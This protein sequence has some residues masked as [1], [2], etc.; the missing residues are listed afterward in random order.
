M[1]SEGRINF[2]WHYG[3]TI[4]DCLEQ[5]EFQKLCEVR[6]LWVRD[7]CQVWVEYKLLFFK[8]SLMLDFFLMLQ[9]KTTCMRSGARRVK[10]NN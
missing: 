6:W 1:G 3:G 7:A 9:G 10:I 8:I 4:E 2:V 5:N